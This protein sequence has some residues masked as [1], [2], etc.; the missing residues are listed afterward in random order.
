MS[1][2]NQPSE[3][4]TNMNHCGPVQPERTPSGLGEREWERGLKMY[5]GGRKNVAKPLPLVS[6]TS[7]KMSNTISKEQ[8]EVNS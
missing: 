2:C 4:R 7:Q 6:I 5:L 8:C 1:Y 3:I